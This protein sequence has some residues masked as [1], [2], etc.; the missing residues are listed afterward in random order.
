[1][2]KAS[3]AVVSIEVDMLGLSVH[4]PCTRELP[5]DS[6]ISGK[7]DYSNDRMLACVCVYA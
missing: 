3:G 1:M 6:I 7:S 2:R 4:H 5:Y